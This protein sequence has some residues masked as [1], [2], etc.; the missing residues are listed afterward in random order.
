MTL[1]TATPK[2][3]RAARV[4]GALRRRLRGPAEGW[5]TL[6]MVTVLALTVAWSFDDA[7]W[8]L[9]ETGWGDFYAPVAV[10]G[11]LFGFMGAKAR[12]PRWLSHLI[13]AVAAAFIVP[14]FVGSIIVPGA[15]FYEQFRATASSVTHAW[16]DLA[17]NNGAVTREYGH[18]LLTIG[19]VVWSVGQFAGYAVFGHRRPLDAVI[20]VGLVLLSSISLTAND[21]LG[22]LV[23][24]TV[25]ALGLL[26]RSHAFDEQS[27]WV[28][29]RI[30]DASVVRSLYLRGG[31]AFIVLAVAGSLV[32]TATASS[33]P[34]QGRMTEVSERLYDVSQWLQRVLPIGGNPRPG[35]AGFG[36]TAKILGQWN[37]AGAPTATVIVPAAEVRTKFYWR[38]VTFDQFDVNAWTWSA[39][40]DLERQP[41][42]AILQGLADDPARNGARREVQFTI[43]IDGT[44]YSISPADPEA[45]DQETS[46]VAVGEGGYF[47]GLRLPWNSGTYVVTAMV[48][49]EGDVEGG[50][51]Q[52]RLRAAGRDYPPEIAQR[53]TT[54]AELGPEPLAILENVR[55]ETGDNPYDL[56]KGLET[57][58]SSSAF[59][60]QPNMTIYPDCLA[61]GAVECFARYRAGY[62]LHY[63]STMAVLLRQMGIPTRLAEGYL[64]GTRVGTREQLTGDQLHA[65][66]EVYFPGYGWYKFDPTGGGQ[67]VQSDL[68]P[69]TVQ[70]STRPSV[71]PLPSFPDD[72]EPRRSFG[73]SS[74][75]I[76]RNG[77]GN[78]ASGLLIIFAVV[79]LIAVGSIAFVAWER[80]PRGEVTPDSVWRGV[81]RLAARLGFGPRPTQ[82]VY[83]YAGTLGEV[84][85]SARPELQTVA[86]AKVEVAYGRHVLGEDRMRGLREAHRRLRRELLSLIFRRR[87]R[88]ARKSSRRGKLR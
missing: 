85:P 76:G 80:G 56:A 58:L 47:G 24:F 42:Q 40:R 57:Y 86:R 35:A 6:L 46:L 50:L 43:T 26:A 84:L 38:A 48:P 17:V 22:F 61:L 83:E 59:E 64:P 87:E 36:S 30:G 8:V 13:G 29:R 32:L 10:L 63:A 28:R 1:E 70:P 69:G 41:G 62:C 15:N 73:T 9:S 37:T 88:Q 68:E 23:V 25:A 51:T 49:V 31:T 66:V 67:G 33:A 72:E 21:Q 27:A 55:Q 75:N 19:L 39:S 20:V 34:L 45:V 77:G 7:A 3:D 74:G 54:R 5:L 16:I 78:D 71:A 11:V 4:R 12:W 53:Y 81:A 79:L 65:W 2:P 52:E 14:L 82:T 60:Y 18:F 44:D